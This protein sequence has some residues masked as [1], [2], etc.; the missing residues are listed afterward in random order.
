MDGH[1]LPPPVDGAP[2]EVLELGGGGCMFAALS[3]G[4]GARQA[5]AYLWVELLLAARTASAGWAASHP[6]LRTIPT[7]HV[8][9]LPAALA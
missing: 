7:T 2:S 3:L 8:C 1:L 6:A 5:L 4:V 9:V